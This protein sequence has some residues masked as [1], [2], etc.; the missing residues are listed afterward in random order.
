LQQFAIYWFQ[1]MPEEP[2]TF[3]LKPEKL[4]RILSMCADTSDEHSQSSDQKKTELLQNRLGQA[5]PLD[6]STMEA[7]PK[8]LGWFRRAIGAISTEPMGK[9]LMDPKADIDLIRRIKEYA[10]SLS[11]SAQSVAENQTSNTI[12]YLALAHALRFHGKKITTFSYDELGN[13]FKFLTNQ[14]WIDL[15]YRDLFIKALDICREKAQGS[16][17]GPSNERKAK[18]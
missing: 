12:Y 10:K 9:L 1:T 5:L 14:K 7:L 17:E 3:G 16:E 4:A 15:N 2:T 18:K 6:A 8:V 11:K 13:A